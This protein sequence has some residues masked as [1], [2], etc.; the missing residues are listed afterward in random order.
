MENPFVDEFRLPDSPSPLGSHPGPL[1]QPHRP[2]SYISEEAIRHTTIPVQREDDESEAGSPTILLGEAQEKQPPGHRR[3]K[4]CIAISAAVIIAILLG[5]AIGLVTK[6][7]RSGSPNANEH[8]N[9]SAYL[10]TPAVTGD[11]P[12]S[13]GTRSKV[14]ITEPTQIVT[15]LPITTRQE[16][17]LSGF[18]T[19]KTRV[20][21]PDVVTRTSFGPFSY[22]PSTT[23]E[24]NPTV[25]KETS[26]QQ[27]P[28]P[29]TS[30]TT[31]TVAG[32][33]MVA[34]TFTKTEMVVG[35][36]PANLPW[37]PPWPPAAEGTTKPPPVNM[38]FGSNE[39]MPAFKYRHDQVKR[40]IGDTQD[41]SGSGTGD[42]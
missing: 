32:A 10:T 34:P 37:P 11:H 29:S 14:T 41:A 9:T 1:Y 42:V 4:L 31:V 5:V 40:D 20:T 39:T 2:L 26:E 21:I 38:H 30:Q 15:D 13:D 16:E 12:P 27:D 8:V 33:P 6:K 17:T 35:P 23:H 18:I 24:V 7:H 36:S 19:I 3:K 28:A 22:A 25:T